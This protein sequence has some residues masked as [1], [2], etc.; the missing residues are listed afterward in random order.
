MSGRARVAAGEPTGRWAAVPRGA[1]EQALESHYDLSNEFFA[2]WLDR[3]LSYT[4][5][6]WAGEDDTLEDA[7]T[8]KVDYHCDQVG[9][10]G[11]DR[12]LD[13]GCG[14]GGLL[15]RLVD[16]YDVGKVVGLTMNQSHLDWIAAFQEPR[17]EVQRGDW[18]D[19]VAAAPYDRVFAWGVI[20][21][22]AKGDLSDD[23]K[24]EAYRRFFRLCHGWLKPG[25]WMSLQTIMYENSRREDL[26][27][28]IIQEIFPES[29]LPCLADIAQATSTLFEVRT[30]V[31]HR[32]HY[33][34]T[35]KAWRTRLRE[36]RSR[37]IE[38]VGE[39]TVDKYEKYLN[40]FIIGFHVGTMNLGR[41]ALRR[42]DNPRK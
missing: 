10:K 21:H 33:V 9:V 15:K 40:M 31:N 24:V 19:H 37:A 1:S 23:E 36:N 25:G 38:L 6:L 5:A 7:Q 18:A 26:N 39:T 30:L 3:S 27:D 4:S 16:V 14:W 2:L 42:I 41:F 28:F 8:R 22:A 20:E 17:I 12:V 35:L 34:R 32:E 11:V 13:V 29:E